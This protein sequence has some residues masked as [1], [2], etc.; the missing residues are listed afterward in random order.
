MLCKFFFR[1]AHLSG[2]PWSSLWPPKLVPKSILPNTLWYFLVY[3]QMRYL[4]LAI[5]VLVG[6]MCADAFS[7]KFL[8]SM[9]TSPDYDSSPQL[10]F[11]FVQRVDHFRDPLWR[12]CITRC[13]AGCGMYRKFHLKYCAENCVDKKFKHF[14]PINYCFDFEKWQRL[15][16]AVA[17]MELIF[18]V[19]RFYES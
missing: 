15:A 1:T 11:G 18:S 5:G 8:G 17:A 12:P 7:M 4:I 14:S 9:S 6:S 10:P 13:I 16:W 3:F 2:C 19:D